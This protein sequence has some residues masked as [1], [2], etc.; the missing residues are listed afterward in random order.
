MRVLLLALGAAVLVA[1]IS[2]G[3]R[4]PDGHVGPGMMPAAAG[5]VMLLA[6][7][8]E[9]LK[10]FRSGR[11]ATDG[12]DSTVSS[13]A[14]GAEDEDSQLDVF[15]RT[16]AQRNR[17][18]AVVFGVIALGV[19]LTYAI[20]LLLGLSLMVAVLLTFV[21]KKPL[22]VGVVWGAGAFAFGYLVFGLA[23]NVP[24]ATGALGLI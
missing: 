18:V 15:G 16:T 22:W 24:L 2:Y 23:L 5:A 4:T 21:E 13:G 9:S 10:A 1:G 7:A 17:A 8:W 12:D 3:V 20:G 6:G 19:A 14:E 11:E